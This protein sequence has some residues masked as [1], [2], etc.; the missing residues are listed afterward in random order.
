MGT[1]ASAAAGTASGSPA[2]DFFVSYT[3]AD[4]AWATWVAEV[5]EA[6]GKSVV[7]QAWDSLAGEN[8]V[9]WISTQMAAA[10]RTVAVCSETYF[11]SHWCIQEWTGALAR[12]TLTPLRVADCHDPG[13][14][15]HDQLPGPVRRGRD[16]CATPPRRSRRP[17]QAC[18]GS[19][20]ARTRHRCRCGRCS[21][22]SCPPCGTCRVVTG[23]SPARQAQLDEIRDLLGRGRWR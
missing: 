22:A 2:V 23:F 6:E 19:P 18:P 20:T 13:G 14:A 12:R 10:T 5:L 8:F 11:A 7:V 1:G 17:G 15:G 3:G 4:E 9:V 16:S 21:R